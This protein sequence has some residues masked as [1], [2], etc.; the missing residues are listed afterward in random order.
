MDFFQHTSNISAV[1]Q[2]IIWYMN[3]H[4]VWN[5]IVFWLMI[6]IGE[7]KIKGAYPGLIKQYLLGLPGKFLV[8]Q[9]MSLVVLVGVLMVT[10]ISQASQE[11]SGIRLVA[12]IN[13]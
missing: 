11:L 2:E 5:V 6:M 8:V 3:F 9:G 1:N 13:W 12:L 7:F 10:P 4:T